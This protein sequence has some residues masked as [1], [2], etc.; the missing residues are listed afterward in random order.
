[1]RR[2]F[3]SHKCFYELDLLTVSW[4]RAWEN[5]VKMFGLGEHKEKN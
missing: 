4:I 3:P 5:S 1:M 2:F